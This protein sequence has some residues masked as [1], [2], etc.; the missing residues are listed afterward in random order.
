L[1]QGLAALEYLNAR[2]PLIKEFYTPGAAT[3]SVATPT[4]QGKRYK[5]YIR[6]RFLV[7]DIDRNHHNGGDGLAA[8]YKHLESIA[9]RR[10]TKAAAL[11]REAVKDIIRKGNGD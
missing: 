10:G 9:C 4:E 2:G 8:L 3:Y 5:V 1:R 11:I 6:G 7:L